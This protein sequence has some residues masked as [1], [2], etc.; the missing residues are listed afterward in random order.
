MRART[1]Y[2][3]NQ[4][5]LNIVGA[6][7]NSGPFDFTLGHPQ[8]KISNELMGIVNQVH[9]HETPTPHQKMNRRLFAQCMNG[10]THN[11]PHTI[12]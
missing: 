4:P 5:N 11:I 10:R 3:T 8:P 2:P 7:L 6:T 1:R 9:P 12:K